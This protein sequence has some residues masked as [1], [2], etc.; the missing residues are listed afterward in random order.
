[1]GRTLQVLSLVVGL[2]SNLIPLAGVL[3]W[4]WDTFQLLMLFWMETAIAAFWMLL[5]LSRL[6]PGECGTFTVNGQKKQATP[7]TLVGFF[8]LHSGLFI[9]VHLVFILVMF[10]VEWLKNIHG[11]KDFLYGLIVVNGVWVA[12]IA[13]FISYWI[14]FLVSPRPKP[15]AASDRDENADAVGEI[16]IPLYARIFIMQAAII[17]GAWISGRAG[18]LAPLVIIIVLKTLIDLGAGL[19][20][21]KGN[22]RGFSFRSDKIS[23]ET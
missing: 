4:Q 17:F 5:R 15:H 7:S 13:M 16:V 9:F 23:I 12:L 18:S 22:K 10:S 8:A 21:A 14:S 20:T 6:S 19:N 11:P 1:M 3:Y 2:I